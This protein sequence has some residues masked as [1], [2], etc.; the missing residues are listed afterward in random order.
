M[1]QYGHRQRQVEDEEHGKPGQG[2][3]GA[4][5]IA[6]DSHQE[7]VPDQTEREVRV[8]WPHVRSS[9]DTRRNIHTANPIVSS[10]T[11]ARTS[12]PGNATAMVAPAHHGADQD[13]GQ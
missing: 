2:G 12:S 1:M 3:I 7:Q 5:G 6:H 11:P 4:P 10:A 8:G 9:A 13:A